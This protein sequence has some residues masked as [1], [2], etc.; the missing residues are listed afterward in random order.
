M[1]EMSAKKRADAPRARRGYR[2][3]RHPGSPAGAPGINQDNKL[4]TLRFRALVLAQDAICRPRRWVLSDQK[5]CSP[6][7]LRALLVAGLK[8]AA[9]IVL[10]ALAGGALAAGRRL[11]RPHRIIL[12]VARPC[13]AALALAV[14]T[15]RHRMTPRGWRRI[16]TAINFMCA[17]I[18]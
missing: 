17:P 5:P 16:V 3:G 11:L 6:V 1:P 7:F 8:L 18:R 15:P 13:G 14:A 12:A 10:D 2:Q 9:F 4:H